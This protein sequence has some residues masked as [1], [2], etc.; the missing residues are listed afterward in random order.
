MDTARGSQRSWPI[1]HLCVQ[2]LQ[3]TV[4]VALCSCVRTS[5]VMCYEW[6]WRGGYRGKRYVLE[7]EREGRRGREREG[8]NVGQR[9]W[10]SVRVRMCVYGRPEGGW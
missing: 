4:L 6:F 5:G 2:W 7:G 9:E 10:M 1:S 3:M 8:K